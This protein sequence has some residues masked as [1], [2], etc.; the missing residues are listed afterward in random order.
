MSVVYGCERRL[1]GVM[2]SVI[3]SGPKGY[4]FEPGQGDGFF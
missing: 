3:A 4:G 2:V 1:G